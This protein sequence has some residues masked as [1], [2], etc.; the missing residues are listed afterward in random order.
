MK[1]AP[2]LRRNTYV[3]IIGLLGAVVAVIG[4]AAQ[5]D[6]S[7]LPQA[8]AL[9]P[10]LRSLVVVQPGD[11]LPPLNPGFVRVDLIEGT[12]PPALSK[13]IVRTDL[14]CEAD[15]D[16]VSHC[17]NLVT[18]GDTRVEVR[19]HH[20][21]MEEACLSPTE[22]VNIMSAASYVALQAARP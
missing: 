5:R 15:Q 1:E 9:D 4:L 16:G 3:W 20:R 12:I 6:P 7:A 17:R 8:A 22:E 21:M 13:G 11:Q 18:V 19:H 2:M 10:S 14:D